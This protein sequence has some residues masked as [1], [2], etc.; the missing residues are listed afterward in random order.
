MHH[1]GRRISK[2]TLLR[3]IKSSLIGQRINRLISILTG[4]LYRQEQLA[5]KIRTSGLFDEDYYL[6]A[7]PDVA[8]AGVD[9]LRHYLTFGVSEGRN[10]SDSF[11]TQYYLEQNPDVERSGM[12]PLI[13]YFFYGKAECRPTIPEGLSV[14]TIKIAKISEQLALIENAKQEAANLF[15]PDHTS[16]DATIIIPVFNQIKHTLCC[17]KALT[18]QTDIYSFEVI[19]ADDHSSDETEVILSKVKGLRYVHHDQ[20]LGF[21]QNCNVA[22]QQAR[23]RYLVF[24]NN[25]TAPFANWLEELLSPLE[26]N[27]NVGL[28][29]SMLLY[30]NGTLQE[31]GGLIFEDASG[32]NYGRGK[33]PNDCRYNFVRETDYCSGAS[34]AISRALWQQLGGF[35]ERYKPAY[36]EDTDL[37]FRVRAAGYKTLYTPFSKLIHFEGIS[38]GTDLTTGTKRYQLI[39]QPK[40][41]Q[42]W[43]PELSK[44]PKPKTSRFS[45]WKPYKPRRLLWID[46]LTPTPDKD[47]GSAD[48]FNFLKTASE[49]GWGIS[50]V[51]L[52]NQ[53]YAGAYTQNLQ[54]LGIE[55]WYRPYFKSLARYLEADGSTFDAIV[56]SRVTVAS[57]VIKEVLHLAP[58]AKIVFNTVDLHF[59]RSARALQIDKGKLRNVDELKQRELSV[60]RQCDLTILITQKEANIVKQYVPTANLAVIPISREIPGCKTPFAQR[61]DICFIGGF[62]HPPNIDAVEYFAAAVWPLVRAQLPG[63]K[64]I[65]VG[66]NMPDKIK[67]LASKDIII[68]GFVPELSSVFDTVKLSV[69]PL[70]YGAGMKGKIVSSLSFGVPVVATSVATEGM[71]LTNGTNVMVADSPE[72]LCQQVQAVYTSEKLWK[73]ISENGLETARKRFSTQAIS[74]RIINLLDEIVSPPH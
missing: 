8:T 3:Q 56:L 55:C 11:N 57:A 71:D 1:K 16:P 65:V 22:S 37:A 49:N 7:N 24:L 68:R 6:S 27:Q 40:F 36:Y 25:D 20:N 19:V 5:S 62:S 32:W 58:Q 38:S 31:A 54:R 53:N 64:F 52:F 51:P 67:A 23:G 50:F 2:S 47:S 42:R 18:T 66:S 21:L 30:S 74:P 12:N 10:P 46:A 39:N 45:V 13:H 48:T 72:T 34:I 41:K 26:N 15:F 28:A 60:V 35:D 29:G 44:R 33:D 63:C 69:A 14:S 43:Q 4:R 59:L 70:R 73:T 9:A 17:L 61:R